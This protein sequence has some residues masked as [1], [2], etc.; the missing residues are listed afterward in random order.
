LSARTRP[1]VRGP[2]LPAQ[3][4]HPEAETRPAANPLA[5]FRR[6]FRVLLTRPNLTIRVALT[7]GPRHNFR[8]RCKRDLPAER[9][10]YH[11]FKNTSSA[12]CKSRRIIRAEAEI[13]VRHNVS[14][15]RIRAD[16]G[17]K[18]VSPESPGNTWAGSACLTI[19]SGDRDK[20]KCGHCCPPRKSEWCVSRRLAQCEIWQPHDLSATQG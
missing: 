6:P 16:S 3:A 10:Q 15:C 12:R 1:S 2:R 7:Q 8:V 5:T 9:I 4:A 17:F 11:I 18:C 20:K 13:V 14:N 19:P